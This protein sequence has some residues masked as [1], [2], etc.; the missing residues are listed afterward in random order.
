MIAY[1]KRAMEMGFSVVIT[2]PNEVF[3]YKDK[4]VVR[5]IFF[6]YPI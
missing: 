6:F 3:W 2:N 5:I 1:T 4:G